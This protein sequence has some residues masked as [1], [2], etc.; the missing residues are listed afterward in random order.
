[1]TDDELELSELPELDGRDHAVVAAVRALGTP[2]GAPDWAA[3]EASIQ[4]ATTR[5]P[6]HRRRYLL[7]AAIG[8]AALAAGVAIYLAR[9]TGHLELPSV[10]ATIT[11]PA[12]EPDVIDEP[13]DDDALA[14]DDDS[15]L[16][17]MGTIDDALADEVIALE[18]AADDAAGESDDLPAIGAAWTAWLDDF[19]EDDLDLALRWLD[20]QE[21]T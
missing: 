12:V 21:A 18:A 11:V 17:A 14:L 6:R 4:A 20:T 2:G 13:L 9:P 1:M 16:G 7:G 3:L 10:A 8:V 15:D 19:S 5:A